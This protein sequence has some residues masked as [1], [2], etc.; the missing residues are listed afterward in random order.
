MTFRKAIDWLE[1]IRSTA[2]CNEFEES[3]NEED[4]KDIIAS[5]ETALYILNKHDAAAYNSDG[6]EEDEEDEDV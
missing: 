4:R 6:W 2:M 5:M 1:N 3:V